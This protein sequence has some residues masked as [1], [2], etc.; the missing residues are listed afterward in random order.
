MS[1]WQ[2]R[3]LLNCINNDDDY[4][5]VSAFKSRIENFLRQVGGGRLGNV[6]GPNTM[7]EYVN[8]MT[9]LR[10]IECHPFIQVV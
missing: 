10:D 7:D 2:A 9:R 4:S 5:S 6:I 3:G 8:V 1:I